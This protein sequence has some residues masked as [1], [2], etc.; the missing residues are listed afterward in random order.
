MKKKVILVWSSLTT[1]NLLGFR[2]SWYNLVWFA[3]IWF[4]LGWL[5]SILYGQIW[6]VLGKKMVWSSLLCLN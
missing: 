3:L 6:L 2:L 4:G 1:G 5:A